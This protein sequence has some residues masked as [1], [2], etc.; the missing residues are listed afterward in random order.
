[1]TDPLNH[2]NS[3][4]YDAHGNKMSETHANNELITYDS[5]DPMNRLLQKSV[6]RDANTVDVTHMSYDSAGNLASNTDENGNVYSY[7]YDAMNRITKMIYP[8][9]L[10]EA[11]GY[12]SA[13]NVQTYTNRSGAVQTFSYDNR[14]R[15]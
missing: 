2:T 5:H 14:I 7:K 1:V 9:S 11:H 4:V 10:F 8:N 6:H 12:D 3:V 15:P 13:G